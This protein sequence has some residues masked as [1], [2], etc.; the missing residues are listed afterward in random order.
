MKNKTGVKA[1]WYMPV[2]QATQEA[3]IGDDDSRPVQ[4]KIIKTLFQ[5]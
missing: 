4:A 1:W 3:E 5:K 2:I